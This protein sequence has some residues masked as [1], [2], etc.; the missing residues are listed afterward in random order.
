MPFRRLMLALPS[1]LLALAAAGAILLAQ[2]CGRRDVERAANFSEQYEE[3]VEMKE[4]AVAAS[5]PYQLSGTPE[6]ETISRVFAK[7]RTRSASRADLEEA[8]GAERGRSWYVDHFDAEMEAFRTSIAD[9]SS[10]ASAIGDEEIRE[11]AADVCQQFAVTMETAK[12]LLAAQRERSK[13]VAGFFATLI[14]RER[15][16]PFRTELEATGDQLRR[17]RDT[18]VQVMNE[19]QAAFGRFQGIVERKLGLELRGKSE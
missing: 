19:H 11:A 13:H 9:L 17:L 15:Q 8:L 16:F 6:A 10:R 14:S 12:G 5:Y 18:M 2:G 4:R 1:I 7:I 3:T